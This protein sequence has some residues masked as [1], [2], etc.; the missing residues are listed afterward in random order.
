MKIPKHI[1]DKLEKRAALATE[2]KLKAIKY[3]K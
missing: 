3:N 1:H 2:N